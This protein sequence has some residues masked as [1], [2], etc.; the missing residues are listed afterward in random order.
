M[1]DGA[2][3]NQPIDGP[4]LTAQEAPLLEKR[5]SESSPTDASKT[6]PVRN[7]SSASLAHNRTLLET[8]VSGNDPGAQQQKS[9]PRKL[10]K[11]RGNSDSNSEQREG[12]RHPNR[13]I[14]EMMKN[15]AVPEKTGERARGVLFRRDRS[16][17]GTSTPT[18]DA[19]STDGMPMAVMNGDGE[20]TAP[21]DTTASMRETLSSETSK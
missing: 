13:S 6:L 5:Q 15:K 20:E 3:F 17:K 11:T 4:S 8:H 12:T 7:A 9:K 16:L 1:R 14:A 19:A 2:V 18:E 10:T 21:S